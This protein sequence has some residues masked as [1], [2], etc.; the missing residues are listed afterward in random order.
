M[1]NYFSLF[2]LI[3]L[4]IACSQSD[5]SDPV[6]PATAI[7]LPSTLKSRVS[8]DNEFA[9]DLLKNTIKNNAN[10][11]NVFISP[12]S[13]S[14]AL[15]MTRNGAV[16]DTKTEMNT[17]LKLSGL[18]D[19]EINEYY[20]I[21]QNSLLTVDPSAKLSLANAIWYRTG[22]SVKSDFLQ[23]ST[24]YFNSE[25]REL[26]FGQPSALETI[27]NW[28][29]QKTNNLIK[30][31]LDKISD[32]ATMYLINAIYFKGVWKKQFDKKATEEKDFYAETGAISK[33]NMM[34]LADTV[35]YFE[36]DLLQAIDLP[37]GNG[38][39]SMTLILPQSGKT[40]AAILSNLNLDQWN[41]ILRGFSNKKVYV[42]LP[43]ITTKNKFELKP[44]ME[45]LGMKL[46]FTDAA[47]FTNIADES[48]QISSITHRTYL[49]VNEEGTEA[50][51]ITIV[52]M[53]TTAITDKS[54]AFNANKPFILAIR[55]KSTGAILF[56]GKIGKPGLN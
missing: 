2:L 51:A 33:V 11:D 14:S 25:V 55:E 34:N 37:Y 42:S 54:V 24:D 20:K 31:A 39:F 17:A 16:G 9:F 43:R 23:T 50:A 32:D 1:K 45:D 27:N 5:E 40:T 38:A 49:D 47:D 19:S 4:L 46:P 36:N 15:A 44:V 3:P 13:I 30:D 8:Q 28:C 53:V 21:M 6:V 56:V 10:E 48:L 18:S 41:L 26:D 52:E 29:A 22:F 35:P 12:L 7:S